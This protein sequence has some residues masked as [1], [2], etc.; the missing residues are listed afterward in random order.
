MYKQH[1]TEGVPYQDLWAYVANSQRFLYTTDKCIDEDV[2]WL[3]QEPEKTGLSTQK[4]EGLIRRILQTFT[5]P[6]WRFFLR[7]WDNSG[8]AEK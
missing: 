3:E 7:F 4:P 5:K 6:G 8:C 1:L 2:K